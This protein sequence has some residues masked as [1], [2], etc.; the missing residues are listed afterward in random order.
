MTNYKENER[1]GYSL[2]M[3]TSSIYTPSTVSLANCSN[4]EWLILEVLRI[5]QTSNQLAA[6]PRFSQNQ[7]TR[8]PVSVQNATTSNLSRFKG[9]LDRFIIGQS[10]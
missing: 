2:A 3:Q 9:S 4:K 8:L 5:N 10:Y 6:M 1:N 7:I